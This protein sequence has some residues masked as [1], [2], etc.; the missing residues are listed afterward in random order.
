MYCDKCGSKIKDGDEYCSNCGSSVNKIKS[1]NSGSN[2]GIIL[3]VIAIFT[4]TIPFVSIPCAIFAI[5]KGKKEKNGNASIILGVLSLI[6]SIIITLI[7]IAII[8]I[9]FFIISGKDGIIDN[10][11][12]Y[13]DKYGEKYENRID[14]FFED[15]EKD[16]RERED[17]EAFDIKGHSWKASDGSVL[18]LKDNDNYIWYNDSKM[19]EK[20]YSYGNY[21]VY[22]GYEAINYM[23]KN[24]S[25]LGFSYDRQMKF[26]E[27]D[28]YDINN[29]YILVL[30]CDKMIVNGEESNNKKDSYNYYGFYVNDSLKL[31]DISNGENSNFVLNSEN[32]NDGTL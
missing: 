2:V 5:I 17:E 27:S 19:D 10:L 7:W 13:L 4:I 26:F 29:Y 24:F 1:S 8:M 11:D 21:S 22:N 28:D 25:D 9:G 30:N 23:I 15:G 18:L 6:A 31:I 3:A 20:N 14:D 16:F 12:N 32:R